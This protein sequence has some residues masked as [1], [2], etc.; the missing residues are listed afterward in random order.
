MSETDADDGQTY[1]ITIAGTTDGGERAPV[2]SP[3]E[4]Y[5]HWL[6]KLQVSLRES[7]VSSYDYRLRHFVQWCEEH[8]IAPIRALTGWD[9]EQYEAFRRSQDLAPVTLSH[10]MGTVQNFLEYCANADLVDEALPG[11]VNPPQVPNDAYVDDTML[12]PDDARWL[13]E[14]YRESSDERASRGH[15]L[16]ELAWFTGARLGALRGLDL[17]DYDADEQ[18]VQFV[19]EPRGGTPLKNGEDGERIVGLPDDVCAV[20]D[21]Y[22]TT[23]CHQVFDEYGREP[24]FASEVGRPVQNTVRSWMYLATVPCHHSPCPHDNDPD[25]CEYLDFTEASKCPS[26]R[27]PHQVRT[28]SI[29]WQL[30]R[31]IPIDVVSKRVNS[32]ARTI[33]TH[34]D[35]PDPVEEMKKRR[36]PHLDRLGFDGDDTGGDAQ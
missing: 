33:E 7:T 21:E 10:E 27:S 6:A 36:R 23:N 25:T 18:Y 34:Y 31:G 12:H 32:S 15:A 4:A 14:H 1:N 3:R 28:G 8:D 16:I 24:L 13:I 9:L 30:N 5:E 17:V 11:K 19:H 2:L 29:T 20:L 26:S 35:K 22:L